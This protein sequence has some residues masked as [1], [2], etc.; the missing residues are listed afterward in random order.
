MKMGLEKQV[1][2]MVSVFGLAALLLA[3]A[4][5]RAAEAPYWLDAMKKVNDKFDG[6]PG[7]VAQFGDSIT[8]SM[9]FWSCM[10]WV[11]PAPFLPDDGLPK[12]PPRRWRDTLKGFRAKEPVH[13]NYSGWRVG[14]LLAAVPAV[15]ARENPEAAMIMIGTNDTGPEGPP[16]DYGPNLEKLLNMVMDAHCIPILNTIPPKRGS[17]KG[18]EKT[19]I[20]IRDLAKKLNV[21]LVD[22]YE[23]IMKRAPGDSWDGTLISAD[24]VHP[25]AGDGASFS[26][27]NLKV[28]GFALRTWVNFLMVRQVYF[29]IMSAPKPF[30]E[31]VGTVEPIRQGIRCEVTADTQVSYYTDANDNEQLWNWGAADRL[32]SKGWQEYTLMKFDTAKAKGL[33]VKRATLYLSR[34]S[35]VTHVAGI[36][37][38]SSDWAEGKGKGQPDKLPR[39]KQARDSKGGATFTHAVYPDVPWA[40]AGSSFKSVVYGQGGSLWQAVGTGWAKDDKGQDYYSV[41][42]PLDIAQALLVGD[43]SYGLSIVDEKGQR[44]F[45]STYRHV[46]DPNHFVNSRESG[47]PCFLVIEGE[48]VPAKA[49]GAVTA[50]EAKTGVEAGDVELSWL[51]PAAA[52]GGK[53]LGYRVYVSKEKLVSGKL[54]AAVRLPRSFTWRPGKPGERQAF[55]IF[56]L[57]P[58]AEYHFAVVA[59]D[60]CG[61]ESAPAIFS[62]KAREAR[63]FKIVSVPAAKAE[64][65]P[66][67][68]AALRVW[69]CASGEKINPLT[70]NALSEGAYTGKP[71][72]VYRNGNSVWDGKQQL[73]NLTA[74]RNDFAGFQIAVENLGDKPLA[75]IK[76]SCSDLAP[77]SET[78]EIGRYVQMNVKSAEQFMG[79]MEALEKKDA[80]LADKV[81]ASVKRYNELKAKQQSDP[82]AFVDEM[83][84]LRAKD[85]AEYKK[86][87]QLLSPSGDAGGGVAAANVELFWQWNLKDQS[88]V[89]YPDALVPVGAGP[90]SLPN[91]LN[92]LPGQKVLALYADLWV[93]HKVEPGVYS[94]EIR[95]ETATGGALTVPVELT[96]LDYT[97]PDELNFVCDMNGYRYPQVK[98]WEGSLNLHRLAHRNRLNVNIVPYSQTGNWAV[99]E[100]GMEVQGRGKNLRV[101][102][103]ETFDKSFGPLLSGSAFANHPRA[104]VPVAACYLNLFENW[105]CTVKGNFKFDQQAK[106]VDIRNDFSQDYKDG[107]LAVCRQ[108]GGHFKRKG[109]TRTAFQ[110]FLNNKH[111]FAPDQNFW[112]LDEPMFRDDFVALQFFG[113]LF[114]EGFR[115]AAPVM[116][117]YRADVSRIEE[118]RGMLD[119]LDTM[120]FSQYNVREYPTIARE[121]MRSYDAR[122]PGE[123]RKGWEYGGAGRVDALPVSLRG[124]VMECWFD[125]RDGLLPWESTG[126]EASWES[127][128]AANDG[129]VFYPAFAKWDYNGC[130]GSLKMK[131]FRDGQQDA[132]YLILLAKK[133]GATRA[134]IRDLI[135]PYLVL[136]GK[137][138]AAAGNELAP[139]AGSISYRGLTPDAMERLRKAIG[140]TLAGEGK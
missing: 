66:L 15:L 23:E 52:D 118:A 51:C 138:T 83:K 24:G 104:G 57:E 129:S 76:V 67:A 47:K 1:K 43:D 107:F 46:P 117:D 56:G 63:T 50:A 36:S 61:N 38:I 31:E 134:E 81:Y 10:S 128:E 101:A 82:K 139:D 7:Y 16:P 123:A 5:A 54:P 97:L 85:E 41:E 133:L 84:A 4:A 60:R 106:Q 20:I 59:Y 86:W 96:V 32:K 74:G 49:P 44:A 92:P 42:L 19:N 9:A 28:N 68:N 39:D 77:K 12:D 111:Q 72:G 109:Y 116:V 135:K 88:G 53:V 2:R 112:L 21:P 65:A 14:N 115:E 71:G 113:D 80:A 110:P 30:V 35:C 137:V 99:P 34:N 131:G 105:P 125:G 75:G 79:A 140:L 8:H 114:R 121:F 122:N 70:G 98:D 3:G 64:G 89:W 124:W 22:Y 73:V 103:F 87:M 100:M 95:I 29:R 26:E 91:T 94:G 6:N 136:Q 108:M 18:V 45:Q 33:A 48:K 102:S 17:M 127:A 90:L 130:Y 62:G 126:S 55:P 11:E 120:V 40:G 37:T 27:D 13:G 119:R 25:S 58:G 78:A 132:E 69:A 93:P